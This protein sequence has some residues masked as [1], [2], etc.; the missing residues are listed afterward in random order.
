MWALFF[1]FVSGKNEFRRR[2]DFL[3][4]AVEPSAKSSEKKKNGFSRIAEI[5]S[6]V[7]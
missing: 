3:H 6:G 1:H 7:K 4:V 5:E 2:E